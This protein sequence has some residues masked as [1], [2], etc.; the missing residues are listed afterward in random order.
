MADNYLDNIQKAWKY[1]KHLEDQLM[2]E[3]HHLEAGL[4]SKS[5]AAGYEVLAEKAEIIVNQLEYV[6][7]ELQEW[8]SLGE[9]VNPLDLASWLEIYG[10][11]STKLETIKNKI[12]Q[13]YDKAGEHVDVDRGVDPHSF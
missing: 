6:Q 8:R 9:I 7:D 13:Y 5:K 12:D 4:D 3:E 2:K 10:E 1:I 11:S